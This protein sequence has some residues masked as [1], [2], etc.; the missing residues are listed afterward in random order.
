MKRDEEEEDKDNGAQNRPANGVATK[1]SRVDEAEYLL[2]I[3]DTV[4]EVGKPSQNIQNI[5]AVLMLSEGWDARIVTDIMGLGA[6]TSH[7]CF[8]SRRLW[9]GQR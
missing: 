8:A 9:Q 1:L 2:E 6:F 5:I 4:G 7:N 3:V